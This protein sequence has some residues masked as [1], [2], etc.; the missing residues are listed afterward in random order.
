MLCRCLVL[1]CL[2]K[3][4]KKNQNRGKWNLDILRHWAKLI[5]QL[6][7]KN[8]NKLIT[9]SNHIPFAKLQL[10][11]LL[12]V[13]LFLS[14]GRNVRHLSDICQTEQLLHRLFLIF[15][16]LK[17]SYCYVLYLEKENDG[18]YSMPEHDRRKAF[19]YLLNRERY[20]SGQLI[21]M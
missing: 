11:G 4:K 10:F 1:K 17:Y 19:M 6:W 20:Y 21:L 16:L 8:S 7:S 15:F 5:Q 12:T 14:N 2:V 13:A 9:Y 18:M 3:L